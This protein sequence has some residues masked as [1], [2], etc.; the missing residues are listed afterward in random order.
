[1]AKW[2]ISNWSYYFGVIEV[3]VYIKVV[4]LHHCCFSPPRS[5]GCKSRDCWCEEACNFSDDFLI[6]CFSTEP[7]KKEKC[8]KCCCAT[9][10]L[11]LCEKLYL[12]ACLCE[13]WLTYADIIYGRFQANIHAWTW[14][15][16]NK[17]CVTTFFPLW[18]YCYM[19]M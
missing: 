12:H 19:Y 7:L 13:W 14:H 16:Q 9:I 17:I 11:F 6:F 10:F 8:T 15:K 5:S 1:M 3:G 4:T 2:S 18:S